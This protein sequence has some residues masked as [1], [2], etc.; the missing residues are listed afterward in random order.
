MVLRL[1]S[2]DVCP[3]GRVVNVMNLVG[4]VVFDWY[5]I[6]VDSG[7]HDFFL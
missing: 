7:K 3:F 1:R 5:V 2:H 4:L 6:F